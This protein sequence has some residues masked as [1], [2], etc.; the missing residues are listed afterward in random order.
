MKTTKPTICTLKFETKIKCN[1][2]D[3]AELGDY[4]VYKPSNES[5]TI[6]KDLTGGS[7]D[8]TIIPSNFSEWRVIRKTADSIEVVADKTGDGWIEFGSDIGYKNL[9]GI[10]NLASK[11]M[12]TPGITTGSRHMGYS[13]QTEYCTDLCAGDTGY[14]LDVD[15]VE[16][17]IGSLSGYAERDIF[18][19]QDIEETTRL[20][21]IIIYLD[22]FKKGENL[23]L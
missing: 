21:D 7:K 17:S 4:V 6:S 19:H 5:Y 18:W 13:N 20:E 15:L 9:I 10:L 22:G 11:Q 3:E 23:H 1:L 2:Y 12:E 14:Q 8:A 16:N